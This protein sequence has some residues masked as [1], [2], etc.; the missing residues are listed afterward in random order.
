MLAGQ[1]GLGVAGE[2]GA[3]VVPGGAGLLA[4]PP[5]QPVP[6]GCGREGRRGGARFLGRSAG[7]CRDLGRGL[8]WPD[9]RRCPGVGAVAQQGGSDGTDR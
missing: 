8:I 9:W 1:G 4:A 6:G 7:S 5:A 3:L 2:P